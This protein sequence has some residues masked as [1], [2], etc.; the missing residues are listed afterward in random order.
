M[1]IGSPST[2]TLCASLIG[3]CQYPTVQNDALSFPS[4]KPKLVRPS[5][6]GKT[7]IKVTHFSDTHI[8][9][10][11]E[12][13]SSY[14]CSKPICCRVFEDQYAPGITKTP[15]GPFGNPK[16]DPPLE[17][18]ESMS[19][20]IA[21][22]NPEFSIYTGDVVAHDVWLVNQAEAL[23]SFNRTYGEMEKTLGVVY[24]AIGNHDTAPLNLFSSNSGPDAKNQ[25][26]YN[27]LAE[28]W[29]SLTGISSVQS[30]DEYG[31]YSA[32]HPNSNLRIISY[33]SIFYYK[34]NFYM[35]QEPMEKDP[36]G[37]FEWLIKELQAAEDAGQR[38]WLISHIPSGIPDHFHD[39]SQ[40]FDQIVQR[41]EATIAGLFYGHTH[42]DEFQIA[43]SNYTNRAHDTATAVGYIVPAMTPTEGSPSFRV[44]EIDPDTFGV[45]DYTQYI[46]NISDP[47]YQK[48]PEWLPYYSAKA[49]YGSKLLPP[50]TDPKVELTPAF[51]HNVTVA[52]ERDPSIFHEFWARRFRGYNF[53]RCDNE[54]MNNKIC[55][56]RAADAQFNCFTP[57]PGF[58]LSRR[59]GEVALLEESRHC[60][61]G[62]LATL[63]GRIAH[64]ARAVC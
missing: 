63:L 9:L 46:A 28:D 34:F 45:L 51:W 32:I 40:Y 18:Q 12:T 2:Q 39:Y 1:H 29:F 14:K 58:N 59:D 15:C 22:I 38:A 21:E 62:G 33:N 60:D 23:D 25:W 11:Y 30:A 44:Y 13:G 8:D 37:Q 16:C 42:M 10:Y 41:Y 53:T 4:R 54:C 17:L 35:Y 7:P 5:P 20:A 27:A 47:T 6:S 64:R 26:A 56:L 52:M 31:S 55:A 36:N 61:H 57:K 48:K 43:Y 19:A 50:V 49:D 3:L 24:A